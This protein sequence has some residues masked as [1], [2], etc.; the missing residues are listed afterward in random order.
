[1]SNVKPCADCRHFQRY[2]P[3]TQILAG[4]LGPVRQAVTAELSRLMQDER[5]TQDAEATMEVELERTDQIEWPHPPVMTDCCALR[6]TEGVFQ[7]YRLKNPDDVCDDHVRG[8]APQTETCATC[9][10]R[11]AGQGPARDKAMMEYMQHNADMAIVAGRPAG[12][13]LSSYITSVDARQALDVAQAYYHGRMVMRPPEYLAHCGRFSG[14]RAFI[15]CAVQNPH[16]RCAG[17]EPVGAA[18]SDP[19][20]GL[21]V[22][23]ADQK[24]T[25]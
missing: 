6:A 4:E 3:R 23:A 18:A 14:P 10:H 1:M 7:A 15:P 24:A 2:R 12:S 5:Q 11:V 8:A 19:P 25:S 16:D 9:R 17:W 20:T 22:A 21:F 13:E